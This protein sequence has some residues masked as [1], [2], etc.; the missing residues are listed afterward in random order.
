MI[1][2]HQ[3]ISKSFSIAS[4]ESERK[5]SQVPVASLRYRAVKPKLFLLEVMRIVVEIA[6]LVRG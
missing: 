5:S 6:V 2:I 3:R 4:K 1:D